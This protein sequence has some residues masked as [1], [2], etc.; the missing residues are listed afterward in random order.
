MVLRHL[1]NIRRL[2][3]KTFEGLL[4]ENRKT[5]IMSALPHGDS[6]HHHSAEHEKPSSKRLPSN[7]P[8][9]YRKPK[10]QKGH[11]ILPTRPNGTHEEVLSHDILNL[12]STLSI[13]PDKAPVPPLLD[14]GTELTLQI[15]TLS[16]TGSGIATHDSKIYVVPFTYPGDT[17]L[18]RIVRNAPR[19]V[20]NPAYSTGYPVRIL[21]PSPDRNDKLVKCKYFT[22]CSGCQLQPLPYST[23]L[24][25]K[26]RIIE[27]AYQNFS[28]LPASSV[29]KVAETI[30]SPREYGYRTKLTPHFDGPRN[31]RRARR[32]GDKPDWQ[33]VPAIGFN[34]VEG[35][36]KGGGRAKVLDVEECPIGTDVVNLGM[37]WERARVA[38]ELEK[39]KAG[40][41]VL[42]RESC[43]KVPRRNVDSGEPI[44][45]SEGQGEKNEG[46]VMIGESKNGRPDT[47]EANAAD[48]AITHEHTD[49]TTTLRK[50]CI[51]NHKST[52]TE[53]IDNF[54]FTN[55][56]NAFFQNNNSILPSFTAY[57][58]SKILPTTSS[59]KPQ[60]TNLIDAYCG[61]GLFSI[62]LHSLFTNTLGIDISAESIAS[63]NKN[64][65]L[66]NLTTHRDAASVNATD[67]K[68]H[69]TIKF[70]A[71]DAHTLFSAADETFIGENTAVIID[72]PRKGCDEGF[73]KQLWAFAPERIVYVS[74]NVHTQARDV[75]WLLRGGSDPDT[76]NSGKEDG[77]KEASGDSRLSGEYELVSLQGF[78]FFPQTAHVESVAVLQ[79][80]RR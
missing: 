25:H 61:S 36:V 42:L 59:S 6:S 48:E 64:L 53:Y 27:R 37:K 56:A 62:T 10:K 13:K 66:N 58:R 65:E 2:P 32:R 35:A 21:T 19:T 5:C 52:T 40:A 69:K 43:E 24:A 29:P 80:I 74:C 17:V 39:Y 41:T 44:E 8:P 49:N 54:R 79:R 14:P 77:G 34:S 7:P 57:I 15:S 11:P 3:L 50:T 75:G 20:E 26:K 22:T 46:G 73:L 67:D 45:A 71:G 72:P 55:P 47:H 18:A 12:L 38:R 28:E 31:A 51:S 16:S 63:A 33:G 60:I 23:Q 68:Q 78:D 76:R 70:V 1:T 9:P 4:R 30:P